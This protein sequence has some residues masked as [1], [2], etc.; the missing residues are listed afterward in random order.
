MSLKP[1]DFK[2]LEKLGEPE[3]LKEYCRNMATW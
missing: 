2:W 3:E 1:D